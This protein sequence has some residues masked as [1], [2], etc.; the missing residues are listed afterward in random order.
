MWP[1]RNGDPALRFIYGT[2][3]FVAVFSPDQSRET[4]MIEVRQA[5]F[6]YRAVYRLDEVNHCPGCGQSQW[7]VGRLVAEC[8]FCHAALPITAG[9]RIGPGLFESRGRRPA[10]VPLAA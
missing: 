7:L 6:G 3:R 4:V 8:P 1:A 10:T 5:Q 9:S 2:K